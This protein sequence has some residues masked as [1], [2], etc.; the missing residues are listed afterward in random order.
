MVRR[1]DVNEGATELSLPLL[2]KSLFRVCAAAKNKSG[3]KPIRSITV[4][5]SF[6][7]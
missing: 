7:N 4:I 2:T 1:R 5:L 3:N 6:R